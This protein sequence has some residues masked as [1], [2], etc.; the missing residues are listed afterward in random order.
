MAFF[1]LIA[2]GFGAMLLLGSLSDSTA[3]RVVKVG[4]D[5]A[6]AW[7][8]IVWIAIFIAIIVSAG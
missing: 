6:T 5:I 1:L 3:E 7:I 8:A 2:A 4:G